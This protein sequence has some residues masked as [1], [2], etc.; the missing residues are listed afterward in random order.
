VT[1]RGLNKL[2]SRE[3]FEI[4]EQG[5][6]CGAHTSRTLTPVLP[7]HLPLS[8]TST[9]SLATVRHLP[10]VHSTAPLGGPLGGP[11][12]RSPQFAGSCLRILAYE[13]RATGHEISPVDNVR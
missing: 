13:G 6:S 4:L 3:I 2:D 8:A 1:L 5:K 10:G 9:N 11:G 12:F 7:T